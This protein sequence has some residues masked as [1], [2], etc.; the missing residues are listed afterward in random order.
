MIM[1]LKTKQDNKEA[2]LGMFKKAKDPAPDIGHL[3]EDI[4]ELGRR[5][6]VL[7][8]RYANLQNKAQIT[9]QN[10]ISKSRLTQT[11]IKTTNS[12]VHELKNEINQLK[13]QFLMVMKE[14]QGMA[15]KED[16]KVLERY[17]NMWEPVKFVTHDEI[18]EL[19]HNVIDKMK[20][21]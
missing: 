13:T 9:E 7:E 14:L 15:R 5:L 21:E 10:M 20:S 4:N 8:E 1:L 17:L 16:V 19:I 12:D 3:Y 18:E 2:P 6:R 11:E